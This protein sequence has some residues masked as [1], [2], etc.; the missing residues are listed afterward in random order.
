MELLYEITENDKKLKHP[1]WLVIVFCIVFLIPLVNIFVLAGYI[2]GKTCDSTCYVK[3]V[4]TK[5][6]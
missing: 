2:G 4:F 6:I 1:L 5:E 3:S